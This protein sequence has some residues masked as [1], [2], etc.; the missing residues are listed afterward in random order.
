MECLNGLSGSTSTIAL[1]MMRFASGLSFNLTFEANATLRQG[2]PGVSSKQP[3]LFLVCGMNPASNLLSCCYR[4]WLPTG[5]YSRSHKT[6]DS[7]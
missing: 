5:P 7:I 1:I 3:N 6:L 4:L 2:R